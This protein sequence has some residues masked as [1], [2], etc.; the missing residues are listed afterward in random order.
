MKAW[1]SNLGSALLAVSLAVAV[2][3]V[4]VREEYPRDEFSQPIPVSRTG[5]ASN[6]TVFGDILSDVRIEIRAPK[7]RWPNLQARDFTAWIDLSGL[8]AGE[9]DVKVQVKAPDP[10]VQVLAVDPPM[11]RVR[12]EERKEKLLPVRVN[13]MDAP[14]F[15]HDWQ[16]PVITPT[17]VLVSGSG[18]LVDQVDS[19]TVDMYLRGSRT[20][21][22]RTLR[23]SVRNITGD[24]VGF[25][26]VSP[27]DVQVTVPI[28]QL[29]GY[30]E[31]A[32]LVEPLGQPAAG[33]TVSGVTADP[34][35]VTLQGD[36]AVIS[37]LS[38]YI[39]VP[40]DISDASA[41]VVERVPLH[42]PE[43]VSPLDTQSVAVQVSIAPIIGAQTVQRR[44]VIQGLAPGL[45][46]TLT[47]DLVD[48][49]LSG[50]A[51][52]LD[53]LKADAVP[54]ILDLTGLGPGVHVVEPIVP[55]PE[56]IIVEGLSPETIEVTIGAS[57]TATATP[58]GSNATN[59]TRTAPA[60]TP[61]A[62][63]TPAAT[64][65]R[66]PTA[67]PTITPGP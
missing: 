12:L 36:P 64:H 15:G 19:A 27:L 43:N 66:A 37:G 52:K 35:L 6:L 4:A 1:M 9:Y 61:K 34:K 8:K 32:V 11:I 26:D 62:R 22:E 47:L 44:P 56:G 45:M 7:R 21:V 49:F 40:I 13:I 55:A 39:T 23:V 51:P 3:V 54:V 28:V 65:T 50:P 63:S 33:Y 5:L 41:N 18:P 30:R 25:V 17:Q 16:T 58:P 59:P 10:Q 14:A 67:S 60:P 29:P 42:L 53:S 20:P 31:I 24:T 2:W 46:Y 38:G 48:V 57:P